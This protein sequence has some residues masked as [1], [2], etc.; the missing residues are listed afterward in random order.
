M[1]LNPL[2][3]GRRHSAARVVAPHR[4]L[5]LH[6]GRP[7]RAVLTVEASPSHQAS[8]PNTPTSIRSH[9]RSCSCAENVADPGLLCGSNRNLDGLANFDENQATTHPQFADTDG[10]L[11]AGIAVASGSLNGRRAGE[12]VE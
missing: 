12:S 3:G 2:A 6:L 7:T 8:R 11:L 9:A 1:N 5:S 10:V 4:H